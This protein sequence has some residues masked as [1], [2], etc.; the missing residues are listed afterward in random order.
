MIRLWR[1]GWFI[2]LCMLFLEDC[3]K[4]HNGIKLAILFWVPCA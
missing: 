3:Y 2:G 4:I 1:F